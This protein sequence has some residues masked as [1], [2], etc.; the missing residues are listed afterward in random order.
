MGNKVRVASVRLAGLAI[1]VILSTA[2]SLGAQSTTAIR[3]ELATV[4]LQSKK[5]D[6]A[7]REYRALVTQE[8]SNF[9]YRLGLARALAWGNKPREAEVQLRALQSKQPRSATLDSLLRMVREAMEPKS[10]EAAAWVAER[11]NYA[12]YRLALARALAREHYVWSAASQYDTLLAG[13]AVGTSLEPIDLRR[14]KAAAYLDN[15]E[16]HAGAAGLRDVLRLVPNDTATRHRLAEILVSVHSRIEAS[17][18]YDTLLTSTPTAALFMERARLR[19]DMG[20]RRGAESDLV[21]A[22][23][24][25]PPLSAY[26]AL[27]DM[28][29]QRGE[30]ESARSMYR[31]ALS[32]Q[33]VGGHDRAAIAAA[34]GQMA[35][36]ERPVVAYAPSVGDDAGWGFSTDGVGDNL[37]VHY[38]ASTLRGAAPLGDATR[39]GVSV[40]HQYLGERSATRS[41][42]LNSYGV[43]GSLASGVS[44][45]AFLGR[46]G[47]SGGTLRPPAA[48][49]IPLASATA[50]AWVNAWE[51]AA[52]GS[53]GPAFPSLLTTTALRPATGA[54]D[55]VLTER[56]VGGMLGGPLGPADVALTAQQSRLSDANRRLTMQGYLRYPLAPAVFAVYSGYRVTFAKRST[57]Y[58]DP[59]NYTAHAVGVELAERDRR[60]FSWAVRALPGM[61]WS[62]QLPPPPLRSIRVNGRLPGVIDRS[63][64]MLGTSGEVGWRGPLWETT[65]AASYGLGRVGDYRRLGLTLG[66]RV[67]K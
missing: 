18:Q 49:S 53:T 54:Q 21:A 58:W 41:I 6:E 33:I 57:R 52:E 23:P 10:W 39:V 15:G 51:L 45:G 64:F 67:L 20:D 28:Y 11:T 40:V 63:A 2:P 17:A 22:L 46:L 25:N 14:E 31:A 65:A 56:S 48:K 1:L 29:R 42:D 66:A 44:H 62:R 3:A 50:A 5:Y 9:D 24:L 61:A 35:R 30:Y 32:A 12:P 7:A 36:D 38:A 27:G 59:F 26:L 19:L 37:G 13:G 8:P 16:L 43:E 47:V 4:L 34:I 60:G 55:N